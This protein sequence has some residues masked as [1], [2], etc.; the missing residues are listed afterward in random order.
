MRPRATDGM[1]VITVPTPSRGIG[2]R[3]RRIWGQL[4]LGSGHSSASL[5]LAFDLHEV[6]GS[7]PSRGPA[8]ARLLQLHR[9]L[10]AATP[11]GLIATIPGEAWR[12][13]I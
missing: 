8:L 10:G 5:L 13:T 1:G 3:L 7:G 4:E 9:L 6:T 2:C 11:I 12:R